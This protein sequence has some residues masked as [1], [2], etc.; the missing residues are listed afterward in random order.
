VSTLDQNPALQIDA[1]TAA[2]CVRIF[3]DHASGT[4]ERR[5]QLDATL[6]Y[7]RPGDVLTVWRLDRLGRSMQHLTTIVNDLAKRDI[8]F[9]SLTEGFDTTTPGGK[10][11][12]HMFA[13]LAEFERAIIVERTR[14]GLDAARARGKLGGRKPKITPAQITLARKLRDAG[15]HSVDEIAAL[16]GV[17]RATIYRHLAVTA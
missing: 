12:F 6:D 5:P 17:S 11:V 8:Q 13:A 2:G 15:E 1:L 3:T 9:C 10:L 14:A 16:V 7:L 4:R